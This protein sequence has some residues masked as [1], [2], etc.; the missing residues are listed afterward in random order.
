MRV[1]Y[2][3]L[4]S[5]INL[6]LVVRLFIRGIWLKTFNIIVLFLKRHALYVLL[7][8][9]L[10]FLSASLSIFSVDFR[11]S[12]SLSLSVFPSNDNI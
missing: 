8:P 3:R 6:N 1:A 2:L 5:S 4:L 10:L 11:L 12:L 9:F 7:Y